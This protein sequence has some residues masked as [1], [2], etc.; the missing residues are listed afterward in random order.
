MNDTSVA[1]KVLDEATVQGL[2]AGV[3]GE[4]LR[5]DDNGYDA[6]R[7]IWNAMTDNRV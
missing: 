4:L 5:P 1:T 7:K 2:R 6:A 3:R